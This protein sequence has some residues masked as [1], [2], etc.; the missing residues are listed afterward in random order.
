MQAAVFADFGVRT[1]VAKILAQ[2]AFVHAHKKACPSKSWL[3]WNSPSFTQRLIYCLLN[4]W[5]GPKVT[6]LGHVCHFFITKRQKGNF[7]VS[8]KTN[9]KMLI[10]ALAW[11]RTFLFVFWENWKN[12]KSPFDINWP[13][14][15]NFDLGLLNA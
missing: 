11:G 3:K 12:K 2:S 4:Q 10:F 8:Q 13:L 5:V 6:T 15:S 7:S 1:V 9:L 14:V